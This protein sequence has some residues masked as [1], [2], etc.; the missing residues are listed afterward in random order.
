MIKP[1]TGPCEAAVK[2]TTYTIL[3][4]LRAIR[5]GRDGSLVHFRTFGKAG[6]VLCSDHAESKTSVTG[7]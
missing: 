2:M 4:V 7:F 1:K 6:L 5:C 3:R